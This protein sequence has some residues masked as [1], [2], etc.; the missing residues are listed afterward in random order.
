MLCKF[1][2]FLSLLSSETSVF[3]LTLI[4][5]DRFVSV[6]FPF[7][8]FR[9]TTTSVK[10]IGGILWGCAL[11]ISIVPVVVSGPESDL[12]DLSDVCIG[13]PL[14]TRPTSF[15]LQESE[16][17]NQKT[18]LSFAHPVSDESQSAWFFSI[19]I[20]LGLNL[21]C[22]LIILLCYIAVF[23]G[24]R[25]SS[26]RVGRKKRSRDEEVRIAVKMAVI[27]GTDFLC[28]MP[29]ILMGVLAQT[30]VAVIPLEAYTWSVVFILP[31]NSSLNPYL[32]TITT[33]L[34]NRKNRVGPSTAS[35]T[36]DTGVSMTSRAQDN[37]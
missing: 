25:K 34:S 2:G 37:K 16:V 35:N 21:I 27:I 23:V 33:I 11:V 32:Y 22:F 26:K 31:I 20:F 24:L 7:S 14:I 18:G 1:A 15:T 8:R 9:F 19:A 12:Y 36:Q 13:L 4:S 30:G 5:I 17:G 3:Y 10:I 28:W 6:V 29:V